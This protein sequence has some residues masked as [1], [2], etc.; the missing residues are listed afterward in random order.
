[1]IIYGTKVIGNTIQTG[2][3]NCSNCRREEN[4]QLVKY[5]KF[6]H[7]FFIPLI[8]I[9]NLGDQLECYCCKTAYIPGTVLSESEYNS[10]RSAS[11]NTV[12]NAAYFDAI[13]AN[14]GKRVGAFIIDLAIIYLLTFLTV[15]ISKSIVLLLG[16]GFL[17]FATCDLFLKGSS[18]GKLILSMKITEAEID[19]KTTTVKIVLRNLLKGISTFFPVIFLVALLNERKQTI[20]DMVARTV[21]TDRV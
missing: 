8:P 17:Y 9:N 18:I 11:E 3:F 19:E 20:H 7:I 2:R 6:F 16:L 10:A 12:V 5:K 4:Y 21:V 1:M 13:P 15:M 14:F